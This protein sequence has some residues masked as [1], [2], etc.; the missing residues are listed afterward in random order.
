MKSGQFGSKNFPILD[1][2]V[3][4]SNCNTEKEALGA[5]IVNLDIP[6]KNPT[7]SGPTWVKKPSNA[8]H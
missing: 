7:K 8:W 1:I 5:V 4:E 2:D 3:L 6:D